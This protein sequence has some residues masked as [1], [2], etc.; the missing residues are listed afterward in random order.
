MWKVIFSIAITIFI[1]CTLFLMVY[2]MA[3]IV[4]F[5]SLHWVGKI[6]D[7][8][9]ERSIKEESEQTKK[10]REREAFGPPAEND[11]KL[12]RYQRGVYD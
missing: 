2:G 6:V 3:Y 5:A 11:D 7:K 9:K 10:E 8:I 1:T 4:V 12:K